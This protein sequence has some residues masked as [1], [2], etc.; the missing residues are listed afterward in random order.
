MSKARGPDR[1]G[2]PI[3]PDEADLWS[4]TT[5][6]VAPVKA[7][8]RVP[9]M[10]T[11]RQQRLAPPPAKAKPKAEDEAA[12]SAH[13]PPPKPAG[14]AAAKAPPLADLDRRKVRQIA[15]GKVAIDARLD[16]HGARQRDA[17]SRLRG[18]L[19]GAQARG[20]RTVLVITGKGGGAPP[21]RLESLMGETQRGVLRHNVPVWLAEP[22]L[23][24]VVLGYTQAA[25]QHGG[26]GALY[27]QLR[28]SGRD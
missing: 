23:R 3:G 25:P 5:R 8:P 24:A 22:D 2:R 14:K 10:E 9:S 21:D 18:F 11:P 27:V 7:K 28:K 17:R 19:L 15:S 12:R 4:H 6:A 1:G 16:L 26:A 20:C 13:A